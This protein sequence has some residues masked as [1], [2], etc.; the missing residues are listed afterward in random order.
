MADSPTDAFRKGFRA[1]DLKKHALASAKAAGSQQRR[2]QQV[3][4]SK[5]GQKTIFNPRGTTR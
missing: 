2:V 5:M 1:A 4:D 3:V